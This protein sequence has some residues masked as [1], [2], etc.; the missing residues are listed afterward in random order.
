MLVELVSGGRSLPGLQVA[1]LCLGLHVAF[2][3]Y[4]WKESGISGVPSSSYKD[5]SPVRLGTHP[6]DH[7]QY[8][9]PP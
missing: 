3:L 9:L 2:S 5:A 6:Y 1:A 7:I 4:V 8:Q